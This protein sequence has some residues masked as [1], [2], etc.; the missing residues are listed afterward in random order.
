MKC[1]ITGKEGYVK[2]EN[3]HCFCCGTHEGYKGD[4]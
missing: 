3:C 2:E 4:E 1:P